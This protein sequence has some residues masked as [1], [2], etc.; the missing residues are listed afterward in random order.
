MIPE[1]R[2]VQEA[3]QEVRRLRRT[4]Q[5]RRDEDAIAIARAQLGGLQLLYTRLVEGAIR[6]DDSEVRGLV[7]ELRDFMAD[8]RMCLRQL[9]DVLRYQVEL[10]SYIH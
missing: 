8:I 10:P 4:P 1:A 7:P 9:I 6:A 3:A 5:S 2:K